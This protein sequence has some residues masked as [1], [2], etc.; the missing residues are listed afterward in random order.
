MSYTRKKKENEQKQEAKANKQ[1]TIELSLQNGQI[2]HLNKTGEQLH[3]GHS[4]KSIYVSEEGVQYRIK[5]GSYVLEEYIGS[6]AYEA[7]G[8]KVPPYHLAKL[9]NE[10]VFLQQYL[11]DTQQAGCDIESLQLDEIVPMM[12]AIAL[13]GDRDGMG[14]SGDNVLAQTDGALFK[15]DNET[16]FLNTCNPRPEM[17]EKTLFSVSSMINGP[18]DSF[19]SQLTTQYE[20]DYLFYLQQFFDSFNEKNFF[21]KLKKAHTEFEEF[22]DEQ[23]GLRNGKTIEECCATVAANVKYVKK[24]IQ[25]KQMSLQTRQQGTALPTDPVHYQQPQYQQGYLNPNPT[26]YP[27]QRP[28]HFQQQSVPLITNPFYYQPQYQPGYSNFNSTTYPQQATLPMNY[29]YQPQYQQG[30]PNFNPMMQP[31]EQSVEMKLPYNS[32]YQRQMQPS[33]DSMQGYN[34]FGLFG[35]HNLNQTPPS[36]FMQQQEQNLPGSRTVPMTS[37]ERHKLSEKLHNILKTWGDYSDQLQQEEEHY[38]NLLA[39]SKKVQSQET[40]E[41]CKSFMAKSASRRSEI[42]STITS[43]RQQAISLDQTLS[44][45]PNNHRTLSHRR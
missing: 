29:G 19:V 45:T 20:G 22:L 2:L 37:E 28:M 6:V 7:L 17:L 18:F 10:I 1:N 44:A 13:L 5:A 36:Q 33:F 4:D 3:G 12:A 42:Q 21:Q 16:V 31:H 30:Q 27:Q 23:Q 14:K 11:P 38:K 8:I 25:S 35:T 43:L 24:V 32:F 15:I 34:Q 41:A 39:Q 9:N 40:F 26:P